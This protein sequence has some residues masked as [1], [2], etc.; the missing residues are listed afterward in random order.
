MRALVGRA[1]LVLLDEAWNGMDVGMV[2]ATSRYL[3]SDFAVDAGGH[4]MAGMGM[5]QAT[6]CLGL[7][8]KLKFRLD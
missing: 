8:R 4:G 5:D 3:C 6:K 7:E 1:P 2:S